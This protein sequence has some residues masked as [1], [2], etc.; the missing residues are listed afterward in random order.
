MAIGSA[1]NRLGSSN[2]NHIDVRHQFLRE[3]DASGDIFTQYIQA[4]DQHADT[5]TKTLDIR[6]FERHRNFL[7]DRGKV[8]TI[9][10]F[11]RRSHYLIVSGSFSFWQYATW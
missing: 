2:T 9:S 8:S 5:L 10:L 3:V 11:P 4:E 1:K 7:L 6:R